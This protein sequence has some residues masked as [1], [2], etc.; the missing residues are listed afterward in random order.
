MNKIQAYFIGGV[1]S[2]NDSGAFQLNKKSSFGEIVEG[3]IQYSLVEALF[4]IEKG[5]IEIFVQNKKLE[6]ENVL[7]KF[8]KNDKKFY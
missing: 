2:S 7:K 6:K 8:Q 3:K 1:V 5:K 4:L